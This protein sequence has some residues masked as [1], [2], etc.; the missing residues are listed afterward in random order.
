VNSGATV[1]LD[2]VIKTANIPDTWDVLIIGD[3]SGS[4]WD[5]ACGWACTLIDRH[6]DRRR[7]FYGAL[8]TGSI[9]IAEMLPTVHAM[10]WYDQFHGKARKS[11]LGRSTLEVHVVTDND[12]TAGHWETLT[13][14]THGAQ[15]LRRKR[16]LWNV[17]IQLERGGYIFHFHWVARDQIGLNQTADRVSKLSRAVIIEV[18]HRY[19]Q[20][21]GH[22]LD[23]DIYIVD[24]NNGQLEGCDI[25]SQ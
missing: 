24:A 17:L 22:D 1:S 11:Q 25:L 3:G 18:P 4:W 8:S 16:P 2:E 14:N 19:K 12:A 23:H 6:L 13:K 20:H 15:K 7:V 5:G 9:A 21:T 10:L